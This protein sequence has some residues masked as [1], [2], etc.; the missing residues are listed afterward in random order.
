[1]LKYINTGVVFQEIPDE[2][3]LSI[4]IS[5]CPCHCPGCH[6][7]YLWQDTGIPLTTSVLDH[8]VTEYGED[9]T[10]I[11]FMGGDGDARAVNELAEYLHHNHPH[12]KVAWYSGRIR[13]SPLISR[14]NFDYIKL[15][16]YI[17]HLGAL[18]SPTTNQRLYKRTIGEEFI[19]ITARFWKNNSHRT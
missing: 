17:A 6:S 11:C 19:D 4:N 7:K 1:M 5:N 13:L 3:T 9:I 16:P 2:V 15:G 12:Y 18:K 14:S 10:C 8:F